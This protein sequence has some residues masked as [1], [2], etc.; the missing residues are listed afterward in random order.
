VGTR[1]T[2]RSTSAKA[3]NSS[4]VARTSSGPL[5]HSALKRIADEVAAMS[6]IRQSPAA[7]AAACTGSVRL[8]LIR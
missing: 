6:S 2:R 4:S 1:L 8:H 3:L 7:R 5:S